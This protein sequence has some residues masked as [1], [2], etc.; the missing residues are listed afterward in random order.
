MTVSMSGNWSGWSNDLPCRLTIHMVGSHWIIYHL[1]VHFA[2]CRP[3]WNKFSILVSWAH[4]SPALPESLKMIHIILFALSFKMKKMFVDSMLGMS[5]E[6]RR[7]RTQ[8]KIYLYMY[9]LW[10]AFKLSLLAKGGWSCSL[11][12][13]PCSFIGQ[14]PCV[15][16]E[17]RV[18]GEPCL[19]PR[20]TA[21]SVSFTGISLPLNRVR[22]TAVLYK[23]LMNEV[24]KGQNTPMNIFP[25][26]SQSFHAEGGCI[27]RYI[28]PGHNSKQ[29]LN[30]PFWTWRVVLYMNL[31]SQLAILEISKWY[32]RAQ[33]H[34]HGWGDLGKWALGK[35]VQSIKPTTTPEQSWVRLG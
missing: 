15:I 2:D 27:C 10:P 34:W 14:R 29:N 22:Q 35:P 18:G 12:T 13:C 19:T 16:S 3:G 24:L 6:W 26:T 4:S 25:A 33:H 31:S 7:N 1:S 32:S 8:I 5:N 20:D 23:Y 11:A 30:K 21:W 9:T 17:N 28:Q